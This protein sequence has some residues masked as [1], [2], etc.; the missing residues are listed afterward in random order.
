MRHRARRGGRGGRSTLRQ[1]QHDVKDLRGLQGRRR[2]EQQ[3]DDRHPACL[4]VALELRS[5]RTNL[6]RRA[7]RVHALIQAALGCRPMLV[8]RI[9]VGDDIRAETTRVPSGRRPGGGGQARRRSCRSAQVAERR[10]G[11]VLRS[12]PCSS[13]A[14][15]VCTEALVRGQEATVIRPRSTD[16]RAQHLEGEIRLASRVVTCGS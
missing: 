3:R 2:V 9:L 8:E 14:E 10:T 5:S 11:R 4:E 15:R 7:E 16:G 12:S 13:L 6:V 1:R